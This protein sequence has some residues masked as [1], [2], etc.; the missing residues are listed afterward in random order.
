MTSIRLRVQKCTVMSFFIYFFCL[1]NIDKYVTT[2][3]SL[4][5]QNKSILEGV[6]D[7]DNDNDGKVQFI[8]LLWCSVQCSA[9]Q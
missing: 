8:S 1:F 6:S 5:L 4:E 2:S 3:C 9:V 7:D